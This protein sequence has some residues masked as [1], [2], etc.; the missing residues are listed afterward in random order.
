VAIAAVAQPSDPETR[1]KLAAIA[2]DGARV[3]ALADAG[4]YAE[5]RPQAETL[6][7]RAQA[8]GDA[9]MLA[10]TLLLAGFIAKGL[11]D[12]NAA[13]D[14]YSAALAAADGTDE[15]RAAIAATNLAIAEARLGH[16]DAAQVALDRAAAHA[17]NAAATPL[18]RGD[19]AY[20]RGAVF[21]IEG[22]YEASLL[23]FEQ[24][25]AIQERLTPG[26]IKYANTLTAIANAYDDLGR[27]G[28]A[29]SA[30]ERALAVVEA[31][32]GR[33]HPDVADVL[34]N[35]GNIAVDEGDGDRADAAYRRA[36]ASRERG[37]ETLA[38]ADV[39]N[40]L[41]IVALHQDHEDEGLEDMRRALA[42]RERLEPDSA[43][44]ATSLTNLA[45]VEREGRDD[46]T[47]ALAL[48]DRALPMAERLGAEHPYVA[49][50]LVQIG[51]CKLATG[52]FADAER[53]LERARSIR[54]KG[55]RPTE[56]GLVEWALART[57]WEQGRHAE[58]IAHARTA[59]AAFATTDAA[60]FMLDEVDAWLASHH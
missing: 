4:R 46:C 31:V 11:D 21:R 34:V 5:A 23:A 49:D 10:R 38:V 3:Q 2:D 8:V 44:V 6:V 59:R 15:P 40:N 24:A 43:S 58:A 7:A 25:R 35:V 12:W 16:Y 51:E 54:S 48:L 18:T 47:D 52:A 30:A 13:R 37:G 53:A 32:L 26:T 42:I 41:A 20:G 19:V 14:V 55:A 56:L 45:E 9:P 29:R 60:K 33:D 39:L 57:L 1:A 50:A 17:A 22:K 28:E 27:Y 36:L